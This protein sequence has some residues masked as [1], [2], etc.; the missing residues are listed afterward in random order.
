MKTYVAPPPHPARA[1]SGAALRRKPRSFLEWKTL[2]RWGSLP[3]WEEAPA[4]YLL[5][6]AR[7]EA[8]VTQ[9]ELGHR[10]R[11][12]QQAVAQAERWASNPTVQF[13]REWARALDRKLQLEI[14]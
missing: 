2:R 12:S 7:E 3:P 5:R 13:A 14:R 9:H 10:L 4:G 8:G 1:L 11:C 6:N